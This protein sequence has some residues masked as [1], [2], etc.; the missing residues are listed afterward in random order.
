LSDPDEN[1]TW[2]C[3]LTNKLY[4]DFAI[5]ARGKAE[6]LNLYEKMRMRRKSDPKGANDDVPDDIQPYLGGYSMAGMPADFEVLIDNEKLTVRD[7]SKTLIHLKPSGAEGEW[8]GEFGKSLIRFDKDKEGKVTGMKLI[9][10]NRFP[11]K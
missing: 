5:D 6:A 3:M 7:P 1:G 9:V 11:R 4:I 2:L 10:I 8:A